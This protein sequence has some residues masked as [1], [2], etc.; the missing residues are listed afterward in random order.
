MGGMQVSAVPPEMLQATLR[1]Y[2][3]DIIP[4]PSVP[5]FLPT[6]G[7]LPSSPEGAQVEH[8]TSH[9]RIKLQWPIHPQIAAHAQLAAQVQMAVA[10]RLDAGPE[11]AFIMAKVQTQ[12]AETIGVG[13][14]AI[15][16]NLI[17]EGY[18]Q[19]GPKALMQPVM[20][21]RVG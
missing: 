17:E 8:K 19:L 3:W 16:A 10:L 1:K 6:I 7:L 9:D 21:P 18:L 2:A 20:V 13:A 14:S 12:F 5:E 11:P 15:I 4:C